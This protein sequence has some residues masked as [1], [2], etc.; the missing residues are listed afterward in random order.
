M[1]SATPRAIMQLLLVQLIPNCTQIR[2][3]NCTYVIMTRVIGERARHS[4]VCSIDNHTAI[5]YTDKSFH[6]NN[7][8][9]VFVFTIVFEYNDVVFSFLFGE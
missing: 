3:I 5:S 2:A 1:H 4:Q 6:V 7:Y 9:C 8:I